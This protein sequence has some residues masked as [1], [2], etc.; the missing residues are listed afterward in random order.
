M[1]GEHR[2]RRG[3]LLDKNAKVQA[4]AVELLVDDVT[5]VVKV[6]F[7]IPCCA[8][9]L[10][11]EDSEFTDPTW[12][13]ISVRCCHMDGFHLVQYD[14]LQVAC[15]DICQYVGDDED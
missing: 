4:A 15:D 10:P 14:S 11:Y 3:K 5:L 12:Y 9:R 7:C 13:C 2:G 1:R 8:V 6:G